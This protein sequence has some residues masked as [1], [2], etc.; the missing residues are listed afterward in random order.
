MN[1][2]SDTVGVVLIVPDPIGSEVTR[3]RTHIGDTLGMAIPTHI[4][5]LPPT[6]ISVERTRALEQHLAQVAASHGPLTIEVTGTDTF[7]PAS[8]VVYLAI[9]QGAQQCAE[10][11]AA[12]CSG[13]V[14]SPSAFPFHPHITLAHDLA[15]EVLD[16]VADDY[17][18]L[19]DEF[20]VPQMCLY[21]LD[22][23][24]G[25]QVRKVYRLGH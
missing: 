15:A 17:A 13:P 14:K 23:E 2:T 22:R 4:T 7:R 3:L 19:Q 16:E 21:G 1:N 11:N 6:S 20:E 18:D 25:W 10:L 24:R 9:G 12:V 5:L 8:E